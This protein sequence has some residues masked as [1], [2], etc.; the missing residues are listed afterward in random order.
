MR[1]PL[2]NGYVWV[3]RPVRSV[4]TI[5]LTIILFVHFG[6]W[7]GIIGCLLASDITLKD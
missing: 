2:K 7:P 5:G 6:M 4:Y 3:I 1:I